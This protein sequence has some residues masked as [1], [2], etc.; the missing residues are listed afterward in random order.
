MGYH[1]VPLSTPLQAGGG[2]DVFVAVKFT[3]ASYQWPLTTD[4]AGIG[5][6]AQGKCYISANGDTWTLSKFSGTF[7]D[8][9]IRLRVQYARDCDPPDTVSSF[10]AIPGDSLVTLSW[11]NPDNVDFSH[12]LVT[13]ST[14]NYPSIPQ[15]GTPVENGLDGIF[16]EDP[17]TED[18]FV[19][20]GLEN[21]VVYYYSAFAADTGDNYCPP[22]KAAAIPG[23]VLPPGP[24]TLFAADGADRSVKLRWTGPDDVD[25]YGVHIRYATEAAPLSLEDGMPVENGSGGDFSTWPAE[26][27][28]FMHTGLQND[29]AYYYSAWAYDGRRN[30]SPLRTAAAIP[31]DNAPPEFAISVLQNP[32]ISNHLD[33]YVIPCEDILDTSL[34]VTLGGTEIQVAP[35]PGDRAVY[36]YDHEIYQ[37]G[38]L[39]IDVCGRDIMSNFGCS[40]GLFAASR[41]DGA[42]GGRATSADGRMLLTVPGDRL[43]GDTY[44]VVGEASGTPASLLTPYT[45]SP[46]ATEFRGPVSLSFS[47]GEGGWEPT[48]LR[49]ARFHDGQVHPL[50]SYIDLEGGRLVTYVERLGTFG[51]IEQ[52]DLETPPL[53]GEGLAV[54]RN[55]PNPFSSSTEIR[56]AV[57]G[58]QPVL[59]RVFSADGRLVRK[60]I[61]RTITPGTHGVV[62]DGTDLVGRKVAGGVYFYRITTPRSAATGKMVLL[63]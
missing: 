8:L 24:V 25:L 22:V 55:V 62:W 35:V 48:H 21:N 40:S 15:Q 57:S 59:V 36:R 19:H 7:A 58:V 18:G 46:A 14:S 27:D 49:I 10:R 3:N 31:L 51:L 1:S 13:Y 61:D 60:L 37:G 4:P 17:A 33:I 54:F 47:Y 23:D 41:I 5:P 44:I 6:S 39:D 56:F 29:T 63:H 28:S 32:Y 45:I 42:S 12:T 9:G 43:A 53:G 50:D 30:Y 2:E 20:T 16:Y 38:V 11:R 52:P 26:P 34:V